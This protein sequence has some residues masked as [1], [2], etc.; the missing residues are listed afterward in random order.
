MLVGSGKGCAIGMVA[1]YFCVNG[2]AL[3]LSGHFVLPMKGVVSTEPNGVG[4]FLKSS[5]SFGDLMRAIVAVT[6]GIFRMGEICRGE[7]VPYRGEEAF[8]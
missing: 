4:E 1:R 3:A 5:E 8:H 2:C 7:F 6:W